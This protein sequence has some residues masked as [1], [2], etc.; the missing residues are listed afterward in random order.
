M[1]LLKKGG[2]TVYFGDLGNNATTL[3]NYF[4]RNGARHCDPS[5]N[6]Y[7]FMPSSFHTSTNLINGD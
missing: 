6:P 4:E 1:L 7:V 2:K 3:I 5:E